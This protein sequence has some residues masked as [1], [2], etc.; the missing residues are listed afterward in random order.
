RDLRAD[1]PGSPAGG[2]GIAA[3][4]ESADRRIR[5]DAADTR[6]PDGGPRLP[7]LYLRVRLRVRRAD[8]LYFGFTVRGRE[9]PGYVEP[10]LHAHLRDQRGRNGPRRYGEFAA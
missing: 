7:R 8:V 3:T 1:V 4:G 10:G 6:P 9:R 5:R 2:P